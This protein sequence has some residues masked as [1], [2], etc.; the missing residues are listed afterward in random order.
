MSLHPAALAV[1]LLDLIAWAIFLAAGWRVLAALP[2]WQPESADVLQLRRERSLELVAFQGRWIT[3]LQAAALV[4]LV[5]G[6]SNLWTEIVPG[7]MCGTGV[8]QAMGTAGE[9]TLLFRGLALLILYCGW[10]AE[11]LARSDARMRPSPI[12]GRLLLLAGPLMVLGTWTFIQAAAALNGPEPVNCC[13]ALYDQAGAAGWL[14]SAGSRVPSAIWAAACFGGALATAF[15]GLLQYRKP[16]FGGNRIALVAAVMIL[17]WAAAAFGGLK[18]VVAPYVFEI[19]N[20]PC[21][22]CFFLWDHHA[23]GFVLFGLPVWVIAETAA[24]M[25]VRGIGRQSGVPEGP[26]QAR[27]AR[28]GL[29]I[30]IGAVLFAVAAA[31]PML[32]WYI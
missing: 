1:G 28:A 3:T 20:H 19:L 23:L 14:S 24:G 9:Q 26:V 29:H 11:R 18:F 13:A 30:A 7:A 12:H 5:L 16:H 6:V 25:T 22:W 21:P 15:W 8:L 27:L 17:A 10:T 31:A 32:L 4:A 2:Q